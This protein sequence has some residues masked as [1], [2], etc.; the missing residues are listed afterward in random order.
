MFSFANDYSNSSREVIFNKKKFPYELSEKRVRNSL[1]SKGDSSK[2]WLLTEK[3]EEP[4]KALI[5]PLNTEQERSPR[6]NI[7]SPQSDKMDTE[8]NFPDGATS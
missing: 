4:K 6:T 5:P 1:K 3:D 8:T 2:K 7:L